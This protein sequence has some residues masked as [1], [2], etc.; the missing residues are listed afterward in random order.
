MYLTV[1]ET[2]DY[3]QLSESK[4]EALIHHN[5]IRAIHDGQEFL[6]NK[7]QFESHLEQVEKLHKMM[8]EYLQE[9]IPESI[10]VKD[11]D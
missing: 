7:E 8:Q 6:I 1:K 10:D 11:E 4:I 5:K 2:A 9:P 3:L